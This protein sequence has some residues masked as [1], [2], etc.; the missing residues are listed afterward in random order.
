MTGRFSGYRG[1]RRGRGGRKPQ[2]QKQE[3]KK[4][5]SIEDYFFY[6]GSS[7]QA[8]DFETTAEFLVNYV[9]KTFDR[10]HDIAEALRTLEPIDTEVWKP[11][12]SFIRRYN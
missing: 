3:I 4:K 11:T 2:A 12:L 8:S 10:G 5:K 1:G 7:K 6:V 9:K